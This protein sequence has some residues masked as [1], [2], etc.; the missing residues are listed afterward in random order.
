[1][2]SLRVK[3]AQHIGRDDRERVVIEFAFM[4][5]TFIKVEALDY[6]F[7]QVDTF[8]LSGRLLRRNYL[9]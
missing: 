4:N 8:V 5:L 2:K 7:V 6:A 9:K 3:S 1:M